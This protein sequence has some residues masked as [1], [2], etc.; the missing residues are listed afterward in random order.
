M[1]PTKLPHLLSMAINKISGEISEKKL[2]VLHKNV[3]VLNEFSN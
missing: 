1:N 2:V 3:P